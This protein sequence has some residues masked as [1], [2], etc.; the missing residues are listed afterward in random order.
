MDAKVDVSQYHV[1][2]LTEFFDLV[3]LVTCTARH[4]LQLKL[5]QDA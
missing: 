2:I 4:A 1:G 3:H 5:V